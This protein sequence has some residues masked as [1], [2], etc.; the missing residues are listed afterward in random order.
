M[1]HCLVIDVGALFASTAAVLIQ[2][3]NFGPDFTLT[4]NARSCRQFFTKIWWKLPLFP[5]M[6]CCR[7][8]WPSRRQ[9]ILKSGK[10]LVGW[11]TMSWKGRR[12]KKSGKCFIM[13]YL[14][15]RQCKHRAGN[16]Y[17]RGRLSTMEQRTLKNV[18]NCLYTNIYSY[19]ETSGGISY[20]PY[21]NV[22]HFFNIRVN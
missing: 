12:I 14:H 10:I 16:T 3:P 13:R 1:N 15:L 19:L 9:K 7:W 22:V 6:Q 20:N 17:W 5:T 8:G 18:N 11:W 21:L 2:C 4:K